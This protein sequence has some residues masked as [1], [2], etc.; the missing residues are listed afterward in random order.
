P[1]AAISGAPERLSFPSGPET[2]LS[3]QDGAPDL[4][5]APRE[6]GWKVTAIP[7]AV[8][9][10]GEYAVNGPAGVYWIGDDRALVR[11]IWRDRYTLALADLR[12]GKLQT[13]AGYHEI[14][15][16]SPDGRFL[17]LNQ[18]AGRTVLADMASDREVWQLP[19]GADGA[20]WLDARHVRYYLNG[21]TYVADSVNRVLWTLPGR[22]DS[23]AVV[24]GQLCAAPSGSGTTGALAC[25]QSPGNGG[26]SLLAAGEYT[27]RFL[28]PLRADST[29]RRLA[30]AYR[31][32][33]RTAGAAWWSSGVAHATKP[34][35]T[36]Y[37]VDTIAVYDAKA[38]TVRRVT[39]PAPAYITGLEWSPDGAYLGLDL[40]LDQEYDWSTLDRG[41]LWSLEVATGRMARVYTYGGEKRAG[42][43]G[44]LN[45][46]ALLV[47][48]S[49]TPARLEVLAPGREPQDW[50]PGLTVLAREAYLAPKPQGVLPWLA[51]A[52]QGQLEIVGSDGSDL[53]WPLAG[54]LSGMAAW[55][56]PA[57]DG[58]W[59]ALLAPA[60]NTS[61]RLLFLRR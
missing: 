47:N 30:F 38:G 57:P 7:Q 41:Q 4:Q 18:G 48:R 11:W 6:N 58:R 56:A 25:W 14:E 15:N 42:L 2:A 17:L 23:M 21:N 8:A 35:P 12:T 24:G 32:S 40:H 27:D 31:S 5:M 50:R 9:A 16:G 55:A 10:L 43:W 26:V 51:L 19:T 29:G 49:G 45:G 46:G 61:G 13:P 54:E 37:Q 3:F 20:Y 59:A 28:Y 1:P 34:L 53:T 33:Q 52:G 22:F 44:A 36:P 60:Q 39:L